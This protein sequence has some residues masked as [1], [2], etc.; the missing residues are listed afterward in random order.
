MVKKSHGYRART[1]GL[2]TK[3]IREKGL[4]SPSK[5]LVDYEAGQR[6]DIVIDSGFHKGMPHRRYQGK[7]GIVTG[8]RG[9]AVLVDVGLGKATKSLIVRREHLRVSKG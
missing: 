6:V 5:V 3:R 7:T 2:M 9:R 8:L 4:S 1:R